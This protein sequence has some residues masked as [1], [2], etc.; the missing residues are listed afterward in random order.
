MKHTDP[1]DTRL[2][3]F[4]QAAR[5]ELRDLAAKV[6]DE[7]GVGMGCLCHAQALMKSASRRNGLGEGGDSLI[8]QVRAFMEGR[9]ANPPPLNSMRSQASNSSS[10]PRM[11]VQPSR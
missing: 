2:V 10:L 11:K 3:Q 6:D 5:D 4:A 8:H 7:D 1:R 9:R